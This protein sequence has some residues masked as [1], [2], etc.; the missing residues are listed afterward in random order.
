MS[1][2][3]KAQTPDDLTRELWEVAEIGDVRQLNRLLSRGADINARNEAGMTA[4][5][6]AAYLGRLEMVRSLSDHGA[7][8]N[9]TDSQGSTAAM[10]ADQSG[11]EDVVRIL[12]ARGVK[13]AKPSNGPETRSLRLI[14]NEPSND[15]IESDVQ[16]I[17]SNPEVR[18]L[19]EPP[20][21][22]NLVPETRAEFNPGSTFFGHLTSRRH[23]ML[24]TI[25]LLGGG[26]AVF[27][28]LKLRNLPRTDSAGSTAP[29]TQSATESNT[30]AALSPPAN[31]S[32]NA[33]S[34]TDDANT[35]SSSSISEPEKTNLSP[36]PVTSTS[37]TSVSEVDP[38]TTADVPSV[39]PPSPAAAAV[40]ARRIVGKR[41]GANPLA[42]TATGAT[43]VARTNEAE[44]SDGSATPS[45]KSENNA[46]NPT[47]AKQ[48]EEKAPSPQSD[49]KASATP[50]PKVIPWP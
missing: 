39:E 19:H 1:A 44:K 38:K 9:A 22:W 29:I 11:H 8:L 46:A 20:D 17:V 21:I 10:L 36:P 41:S 32:S 33:P 6:V 16:P 25:V 12:V 4:L 2:P 28:F 43:T 3:A 42:S 49:A 26:A 37:G 50:K 35:A 47:A 14:Q 23:L 5:M 40:P 30:P 31:D 27:G 15:L 7:D 18:T 48:L 24:I 13:R 34:Q 45:S